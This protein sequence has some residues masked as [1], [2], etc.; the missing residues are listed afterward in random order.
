MNGEGIVM[1]M[2]PIKKII[3][4]FAAIAVAIS[5]ITANN[6][7]S[8]MLIVAS[9]ENGKT[10][11]VQSAGNSG[12]TQSNNTSSNGDSYVYD[13]SA[14][15]GYVDN[16]ADNSVSGSDVGS[17]NNTPS[18]PVADAPQSDSSSNSG[19]STDAPAA[20]NNKQDSDKG[21]SNPPAN[22]P[23]ADNNSSSKDDKPADSNSKTDKS[24]LTT[25]S[26]AEIISYFNTAS[27][28]VK[29]SAKSVTKDKEENYEAKPIDLGSLGLLQNTV[30]GLINDNMGV[31]SE[32]SGVT[33]TTVADK[34]KIYPVE[35]ETW[36]SKLTE[37]DVKTA[38]CTESNGVYTITLTLNEDPLA[39]EYAHGTGH[40]GKAFN[41]VMPQTIKDNAGGA[42]S[43][44]SSLKVGYQ[45]GKIVVKVD[46]ATGNIISANYDYV[47][48]LNIDMFGGITAYFGIKTDYTVK[49]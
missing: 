8:V 33:A 27:N 44:L 47:W 24:S 49:W 12:N 4:A 25:A 32:K 6:V 31:D 40:H 26:K 39:T 5:L 11:T 21:S 19:T 29:T 7:A 15:N 38:T 17:D 36:S 30:S 18:T 3:I 46:A 20:D 42:A 41:I 48:L 9:R 16:S 2:T 45:D 35:G 28:K 43:L 37:A 13:N 23:A 10:Q 22:S 1:K 14:D 34:N